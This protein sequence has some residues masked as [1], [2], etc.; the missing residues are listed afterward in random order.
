ML[1][2]DIEE[3]GVTVKLPHPGVTV[4][5]GGAGGNT[6]AFIVASWHAA[7]PL[8][9][10]LGVEPHADEREYLALIVQQPGVLENKLL[11]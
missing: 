11:T 3:G 8:V 6:T 5:A 10:P 9:L 4:G 7:F 1:N 2:P